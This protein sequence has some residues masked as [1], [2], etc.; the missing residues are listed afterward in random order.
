MSASSGM[1]RLPRPA[2]GLWPLARRLVWQEGRH[3][4]LRGFVLALA[5][6]VAC[7]LCVSLVADRL[8]QALGLGSREFLAAD[9]VLQSSR[10]VPDSQLK[11]LPAGLVMSQTVSFSSMLFVGDSMQ[12]ASIKAV[13]D[14]YPFYGN[15]QL[16]PQGKVKPGAIWL[17]ARLMALLQAK[18]G[19]TVELGNIQLRVALPTTTRWPPTIRHRNPTRLAV[20][21]RLSLSP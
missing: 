20:V 19:A 9:L 14:G 10:V 6:A 15:L 4:I 17:S 13:G 8:Q 11:S 18:V 2:A 16:H 12:L 21:W 5:L 1:K 7:V 3:G